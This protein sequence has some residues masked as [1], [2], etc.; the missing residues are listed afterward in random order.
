MICAHEHGVHSTH[1]GLHPLDFGCDTYLTDCHSISIRL[2]N[3]RRHK[4]PA[5][6]GSLLLVTALVTVKYRLMCILRNAS[7]I[8]HN[9]TPE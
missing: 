6:L 3:S 7:N 1:F 2:I 8:R 4:D 5:A 9:F